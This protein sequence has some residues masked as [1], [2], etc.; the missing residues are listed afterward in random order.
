MASF[1]FDSGSYGPSEADALRRALGDLPV[2]PEARAQFDDW[3]EAEPQGR[4]DAEGAL[5][6]LATWC[7]EALGAAK[8]LVDDPPEGTP[9]ERFALSCQPDDSMLTLMP[10]VEYTWEGAP[11]QY[12][13]LSLQVI[14]PSA[15]EYEL[16]GASVARLREWPDEAREVEED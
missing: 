12:G 5:A 7:G 14:R 4:F 15:T 2:D 16:Y 11:E 1:V 8:S 13:E 3:P 9:Y 6:Y 10:Y